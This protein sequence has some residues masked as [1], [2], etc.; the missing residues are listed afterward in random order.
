VGKQSIAFFELRTPRDMLD[1]AHREHERIKQALNIDNVFNFFVTANHI[2]DYIR[3]TNSVPQ[4]V[5]DTFSQDQDIKDCADLC[6]KGKHLRLTRHDRI[7]PATD[8]HR[9]S[10][11]VGRAIVGRAI[12]GSAGRWAMSSG[13]RLVFVE[14]LAE[15]LM[16][17]WDAFFAQHGL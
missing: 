8:T 4:S 17:K 12:V 7:D 1:K 16:Q 5:L 10:A 6:D 11:I 13:G 15:R 14:E 9:G 2:R 3:K